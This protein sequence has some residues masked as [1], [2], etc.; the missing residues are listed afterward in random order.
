MLSTNETGDRGLSYSNYMPWVGNE[1]TELCPHVIG[2]NYLYNH[3]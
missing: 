2:H 1:T 3:V